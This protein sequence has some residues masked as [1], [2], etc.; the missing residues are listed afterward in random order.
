MS[1]IYVVPS[2]CCIE[3]HSVCLP[4]PLSV[5]A[6]T[7]ERYLSSCTGNLIRYR[8]FYWKQKPAF[9]CTIRMKKNG[10]LEEIKD[11]EFHGSKL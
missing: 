1:H 6:I 5:S 3:Q 7:T 9:D 4:D 11:E 8:L 2:L 10:A